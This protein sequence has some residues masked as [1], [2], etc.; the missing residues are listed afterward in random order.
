MHVSRALALAFAL[1]LLG[2]ADIVGQ[3]SLQDRIWIVSSR[4][5]ASAEGLERYGVLR[6]SNHSVGRE[7]ADRCANLGLV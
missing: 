4:Q 3:R 1:S 5:I 7:A 6:V 2:S